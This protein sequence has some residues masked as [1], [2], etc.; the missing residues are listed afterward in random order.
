MIEWDL[1]R[2]GG[3]HL[4]IIQTLALEEVTAVSLLISEDCELY[5]LEYTHLN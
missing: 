5:S 4:T 1:R 3:C 2:K